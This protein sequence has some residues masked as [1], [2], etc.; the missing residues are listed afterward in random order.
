MV[1]F[2]LTVKQNLQTAKKSQTTPIKICNAYFELN[3]QVYKA[4]AGTSQPSAFNFF[5]YAFILRSLLN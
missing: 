4:T 3:W 5:R 1:H 2:L